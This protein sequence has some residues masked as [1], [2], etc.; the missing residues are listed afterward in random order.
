M[1]IP[2]VNEVTCF[3]TFSLRGGV[4]L[5]QCCSELIADCDFYQPLSDFRGWCQTAVKPWAYIPHEQPTEAKWSLRLTHLCLQM[6]LTADHTQKKPS[7]LVKTYDPLRVKKET[8]VKW[9]QQREMSTWQR[10]IHQDDKQILVRW[11]SEKRESN[12][13]PVGGRWWGNK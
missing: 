8:S 11:G 7:R 12:K 4:K 2:K 13:E 1:I 5:K 6:I 9:R 10:Q 3:R